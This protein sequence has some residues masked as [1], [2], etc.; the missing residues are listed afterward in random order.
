MRMLALLLSAAALVA[1][2]PV[3]VPA[4]RIAALTF[5]DCRADNAYVT[6]VRDPAKLAP[7]AAERFAAWLTRF[8]AW[9]PGQDAD[10]QRRACALFDCAAMHDIA[11]N[12]FEGE[13]A[14]TV[15]DRLRATIPRDELV[16]CCARLVEGIDGCAVTVAAPELL[17]FPGSF[18]AEAVRPRARLYAKKLLGRVLGVLSE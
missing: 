17:G 13:I 15:F 18:Q 10:P 16:Q 11:R 9:T 12:E 7:E 8:E 2:E 4:D 14:R 1:A 5:E 3:S 6:P